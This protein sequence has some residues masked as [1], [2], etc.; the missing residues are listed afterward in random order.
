[1][2]RESALRDE[3]DVALAWAETDPPGKK[4]LDVW[5]KE[6]NVRRAGSLEEVVKSW[7]C[8]VV[9]SPDDGDRHLRLSRYALQ[10]GKPVYV[11]KPFAD[12][13]SDAKAMF[14][15]AGKHKTPL[16]SSSSLRFA[17]DL[18]AARA[19]KIKDKK[20]HFVS[21]W[22]GGRFDVYIVHVLEML[23]MTLGPGARRVMCAGRPPAEIMVVDYSDKRRGLVQLFPGFEF[24]LAAT[25][26]ED[27]SFALNNMQ[28]FFEVFIAAMLNFFLSGRNPIPV[29]ETL[30]VVALQEAGMRAREKRDHWIEVEIS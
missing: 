3:F 24:G 29:K 16:M 17:P 13:I 8:I 5:C 22:G 18:V 14:D 2:I 6:Q 25:F 4:P 9:L 23:V 21:A 11:D 15:L 28:G 20:V 10:S 12:K 1:M 30:E 7:D 26:G 19:D 27:E